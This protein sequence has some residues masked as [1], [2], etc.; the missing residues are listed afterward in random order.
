MAIEKLVN[1]GHS[2]CD[3]KIPFLTLDVWEHAYY[4]DERNV[5]PDYVSAFWK[6]V[7]WNFVS[8]NLRR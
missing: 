8:Q 3:C 7:N 2:L 1:A 5:R 6:I 4:L